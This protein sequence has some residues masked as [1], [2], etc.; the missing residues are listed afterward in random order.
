MEYVQLKYITFTI[1]LIRSQDSN[2][3]PLSILPM[4]V[5]DRKS[6]RPEVQTL[7]PQFG[8][9]GGGSENLRGTLIV[10]LSFRAY[11]PP[12]FFFSK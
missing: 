7:P 2:S 11:D 3:P 12:S 6:T 5:L 10:A 9:G 8:A 1:Y 4:S